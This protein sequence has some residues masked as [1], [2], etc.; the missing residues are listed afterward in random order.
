MSFRELFLLVRYITET[1]LC[2][3]VGL[4]S[5]ERCLIALFAT[6]VIFICDEFVTTKRMG[7]SEILV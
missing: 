1:P 7:V 5:P 4:I 6:I 2:V 3:V